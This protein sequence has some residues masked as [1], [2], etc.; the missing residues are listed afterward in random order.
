M[1]LRFHVL[2]REMIE[3]ILLYDFLLFITFNTC[4]EMSNLSGNYALQFL[5]LLNREMF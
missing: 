5:F 2:I 4:G 1:I 3:I